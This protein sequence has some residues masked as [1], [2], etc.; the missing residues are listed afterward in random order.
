MFLDQFTCRNGNRTEVEE[1]CFGTLR[2]VMWLLNLSLSL[3][4]DGLEYNSLSLCIMLPSSEKVKLVHHTQEKSIITPILQ[5]I[6]LRLREK[7][8]ACPS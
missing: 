3:T 8:L 2:P 7:N 4:N 6:N 1:D 5:M